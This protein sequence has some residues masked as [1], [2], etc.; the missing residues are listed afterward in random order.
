MSSIHRAA[1]AV[2]QNGQ[3]SLE[4][5]LQ[6]EEAISKATQTIIKNSAKRQIEHQFMSQDLQFWKLSNNFIKDVWQG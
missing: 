1:R 5:S 3:Q 2:V 4:A 6:A